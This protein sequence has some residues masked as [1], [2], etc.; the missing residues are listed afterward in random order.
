VG[1]FDPSV[2]GALLVAGDGA[3]SPAGN[4]FGLVVGGG[5]L[6]GIFPACDGGGPVL[7]EDHFS[8]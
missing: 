5:V 1:T 2:T 7:I 3:V 6:L 4:V 8:Y